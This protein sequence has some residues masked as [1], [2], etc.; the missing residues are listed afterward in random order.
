[1]SCCTLYYFGGSAPGLNDGQRVRELVSV[2]AGGRVELPRNPVLVGVG[3]GHVG[4]VPV[5]LVDGERR[6]PRRVEL[7]SHISDVVSLAWDMTE[8]H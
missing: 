4:V 1:M 6:R 7:Q 2:S 3:V 8:Q 5:L